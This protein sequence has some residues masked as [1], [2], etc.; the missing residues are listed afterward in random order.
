[1]YDP[2]LTT[3]NI[4][5]CIDT[6]LSNVVQEMNSVSKAEIFHSLMQDVSFGSVG[7]AVCALIS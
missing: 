7:A 5:T 3:F 4:G 2:T 6:S 1:M